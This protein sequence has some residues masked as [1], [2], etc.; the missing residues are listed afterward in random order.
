MHGYKEDYLGEFSNGVTTFLYS[1]ILT[2]GAELIKQ[3]F[4]MECNGLIGE[5]GHCS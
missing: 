1:V 5:H 3:E 2:K 4:D